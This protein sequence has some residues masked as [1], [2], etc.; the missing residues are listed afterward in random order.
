[1]VGISIGSPGGSSLPC[2]T[3]RGKQEAFTSAPS[4]SRLQ[5]QPEVRAP[6]ADT[7]EATSAV[8]RTTPQSAADMDEISMKC[9]PSTRRPSQD[10]GGRSAAGDNKRR[11]VG[12][13]TRDNKRQIRK[14]L[15][16]SSNAAVSKDFEMR[17]D[18]ACSARLAPQS[19][20]P[21]SDG[22]GTP[23][24][25]IICPSYAK[26]GFGYVITSPVLPCAGRSLRRIFQSVCHQRADI[27]GVSSSISILKHI[28]SLLVVHRLH[29]L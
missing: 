23:R 20:P 27:G 17:A 13:N 11:A 3:G 28:I 1:M 14:S 16:A 29:D 18:V 7:P 4:S 25:F 15:P 19:S 21:P 12:T 22:K 10:G 8:Q 26:Q 5:Q 24:E 2:E 6:T 9:L